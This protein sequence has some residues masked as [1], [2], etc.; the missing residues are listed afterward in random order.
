[1]IFQ[2]LAQSWRAK[3]AKKRHFFT[4]TGV[5]N[6]EELKFPK[7]DLGISLNYPRDG[8]YRFLG[9]LKYFPETSREKTAIFLYKKSPYK[10]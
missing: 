5:K 8:L 4:F 2:L 3:N 10:I 9:D 1:M 7:F 6:H